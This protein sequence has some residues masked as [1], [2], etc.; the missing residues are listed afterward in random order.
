M[1]PK[2]HV[3]H[4]TECYEYSAL[5][6]TPGGKSMR[7][8]IDVLLSWRLFVVEPLHHSGSDIYQSDH[9]ACKAP[10]HRIST[11]EIPWIALSP[12]G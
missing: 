12:R 11:P 9:R 3:V 2:P 8:I 4:P 7:Q 1:D 10:T 5:Q 6:A